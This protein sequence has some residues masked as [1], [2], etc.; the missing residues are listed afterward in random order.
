MIRLLCGITLSETGGSQRMVWEL[1]SRLPEDLYEITLVTAPSPGGE[2][3]QWIQDLNRSRKNPIRVIPLSCIRRDLSPVADLV[4]FARLLWLLNPRRYDAVHFHNAKMGLLGRFAARLRRIPHIYYTVHGWSLNRAT[5]GAIFPLLS[6]LEQLA[7]RCCDQ[8]IFVSQADR[9]TGIAN[10]WAQE[11]RSLL[12]PNGIGQL[13]HPAADDGST[14]STDPLTHHP[15]LG[16][17]VPLVIHVS[18]LA[19]PKDPF[20][21]IQV[22]EVLL[23]RGIPH[24]LMLIGDGPKYQS[25]ADL[26]AESWIGDH[27]TLAGKRDDVLELLSKAQIFCLYSH[28]EGL[29]ISILEAM[30]CGLPVIASAVGGIPELVRHGE[31]GY[32]VKKTDRQAELQEAASYLEELILNPAKRVQFGETARAIAEEKF[33]VDQMV[34]RYRNLYEA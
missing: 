18:R 32:L 27:V 1:L 21:A 33:C 13:T 16:G 24:H 8:V 9:E 34:E 10:G 19:E 12:I 11:S 14:G 31:T 3:I 29:P 17:S 25:C 26:I 7:A 4:L 28:W 23:S 5:T 30:A 20:F 22:T 6:R 15:R 2:L